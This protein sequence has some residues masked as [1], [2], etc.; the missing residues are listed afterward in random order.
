MPDCDNKDTH[1]VFWITKDWTQLHNNVICA[2]DA[3]LLKGIPGGLVFP[4]KYAPSQEQVL[5]QVNA[6][7]ARR[8][9]PVQQVYY[10]MNFSGTT[11]SSFNFGSTGGM[12]YR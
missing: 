1:V 2:R 8:R 5:A 4:Q 11:T 7:I 3:F 12:Y 10:Q 9:P 6:E